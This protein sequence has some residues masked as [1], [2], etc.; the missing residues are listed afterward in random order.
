[1]TPDDSARKAQDAVLRFLRFSVS[2]SL[3]RRLRFFCLT[4]ARNTIILLEGVPK[5]A[6]VFFLF[7]SAFFLAKRR[8]A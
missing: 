1:V 2:I 4:G 6:F 7:G 8:H 3:T 5:F